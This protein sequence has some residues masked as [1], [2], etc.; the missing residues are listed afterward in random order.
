M[1]GSITDSICLQPTGIRIRLNAMRNQVTALARNMICVMIQNSAEN[2]LLTLIPL[3]LWAGYAIC[4]SQVLLCNKHSKPN[5]LAPD[6]M[7]K[8][9]GL[10]LVELFCL[11]CLGSLKPLQLAYESHE[12]WLILDGL[13]HVWLLA[14][15]V[16]LH[17]FRRLTQAFSHGNWVPKTVSPN[18]QALFKSLIES[19]LL[20]FH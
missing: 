9:F 11:S 7:S 6:S 4:I 20:I 15:V 16:K 13:F 18:V 1:L 3:Q 10:G 17:V 2:G 19:F 12:S 14:G 8:Q 5:L